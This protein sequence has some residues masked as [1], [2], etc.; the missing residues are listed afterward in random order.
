MTFVQLDKICDKLD[1]YKEKQLA[2]ND[3]FPSV[4]ELIEH[5]VD[6]HFDKYASYLLYLSESVDEAIKDGKET[7]LVPAEMKKLCRY[8]KKMFAEFVKE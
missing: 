6:K 1:A 3:Y 8:L 4:N 7:N 5:D 2:P